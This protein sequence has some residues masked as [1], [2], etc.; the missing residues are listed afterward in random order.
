MQVC[1]AAWEQINRLQE[2]R[3]NV[4]EDL[5]NKMNTLCIDTKLM[6]MTKH[7]ANIHLRDPASVAKEWVA[8]CWR[9]FDQTI[10]KAPH[11]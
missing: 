3:T 8:L 2:L 7:S 5:D 1:Q 6:D 10:W 4:A 9:F 11:L